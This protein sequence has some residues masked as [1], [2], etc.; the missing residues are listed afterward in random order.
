MGTVAGI[1]SSTQSTKIVVCDAETGRILAEG[2]APH[3]D[4]TEVHPDAWWDA[5][6][7]ADRD[8][9]LVG[10]DAVGVGAQQHGLVALDD[11]GAVVR[12]AL[13]WNDTRSAKAADELVADLGGPQAWA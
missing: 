10:V 7:L 1:D 12:P 6:R 3:P 8:G 13:L 2:Q 4:G 9:L 11:A 5:L